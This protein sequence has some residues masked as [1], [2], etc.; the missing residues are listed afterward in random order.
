[1]PSIP[2]IPSFFFASLASPHD[3]PNLDYCGNCHGK[4][5]KGGPTTRD[6]TGATDPLEQ[7]VRAGTHPGMFDERNEYM[8][9]YTTMRISDAELKLIA[10]YVAVL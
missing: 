8:P 2:V 3:T 5:G 9:P 1:M 10:D 6:L 7:V 4:D